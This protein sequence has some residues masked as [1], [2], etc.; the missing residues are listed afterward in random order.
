MRERTV[1]QRARVIEFAGKMAL[2]LAWLSGLGLTGTLAYLTWSFRGLGP[3]LTD[4][5]WMPAH[6]QAEVGALLGKLLTLFLVGLAAYRY[7]GQRLRVSQADAEQP[8]M[9]EDGVWP[10]PPTGTA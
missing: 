9:S 10:P 6:W 3:M 5:G 8:A 4:F 2:L 7:C 1:Q